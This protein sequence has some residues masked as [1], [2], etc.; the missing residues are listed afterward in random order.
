MGHS[1]A[2]YSPYLIDQIRAA[3]DASAAIRE[4]QNEG[5]LKPENPHHLAVLET[6]VYKL[7]RGLCLPSAASVA[8]NVVKRER[9]I[10][11]DAGQIKIGDYFRFLLP[12]H[13]E[14]PSSD[15]PNGWYVV[16]PSG[17]MYHQSI[18]AVSEALEVPAFSC[19]GIKSVSEYREVLTRGGSVAVSL[20]NRFVI[21]QTLAPYRDAVIDM[22]GTTF[23]KVSTANGFAYRPF[24]D[25]RHVVTLLEMN[26]RTAT[27]ADSFN[28]PQTQTHGLTVTVPLEV[29]D[30]Y[31]NYHDGATPR[32]IVFLP[33]E[34]E[35]PENLPYTPVRIPPEVTLSLNERLRPRA[36]M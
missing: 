7:R 14:Y 22:G 5:I 13:G 20:N 12:H 31:L 25:G 36:H 19:Q 26:G 23:I 15:Q 11:D 30:R 34:S 35:L 27:F 28:L 2:D 1:H 33:P 9:L 24:Q 4:L 6:D 18:V 10:G 17:D 8:I 3:D 29:A 21:E 16:S 32:S